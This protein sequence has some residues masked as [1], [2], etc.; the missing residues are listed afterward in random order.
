MLIIE[1]TNVT[2][3]QYILIILDIDTIWCNEYVIFFTEC[4]LKMNLYKLAMYLNI[5]QII[6]FTLHCD[7]NKYIIV[8]EERIQDKNAATYP[9]WIQ[10]ISV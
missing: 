10:Y 4:P 7:K 8:R 9:A 3:R 5:M 6:C 2:I 1:Y